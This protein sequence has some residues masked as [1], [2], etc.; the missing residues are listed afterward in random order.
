MLN[1]YNENTRTTLITSF[2]YSHCKLWTYFTPFSSISIVDFEQ[3]NVSQ[4]LCFF[5][6]LKQI[7]IFHAFRLNYNN[8]KMNTQLYRINC[9][10]S[11]TELL[12]FYFMPRWLNFCNNRNLSKDIIHFS[13]YFWWLAPPLLC[14]LN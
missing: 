9:Y 13:I 1:V 5:W 10:P 6:C 2:W 7:Y 14:F 11:C 12:R 3:I 4:D 8:D